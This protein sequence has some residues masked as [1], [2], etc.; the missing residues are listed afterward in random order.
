MRSGGGADGNNGQAGVV[1]RVA[2]WP[3]SGPGDKGREFTLVI[4][5]KIDAREQPRQCDDLYENFKV[6]VAPL[7]LFL[8]PDGRKPSTATT[9][10]SQRAFKTLSWADVR[11]MLED[12]LRESG[13]VAE[14]ASGVD[15][16]RH[17]LPTL[18]EQFG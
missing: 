13:R 7:F 15:V 17:Y 3:R 18:K 11:V 14:V 8:T 1:L 5:N 4:E 16:V 6:E 2:E 12:A 10:E 9:L